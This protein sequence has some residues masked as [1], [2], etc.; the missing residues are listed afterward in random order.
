[1]HYFFAV[2]SDCGEDQNNIHVGELDPE[3]GEIRFLAN[4]SGIGSPTW[5]EYDPERKLLY[6]GG[7]FSDDG[8]VAV[9]DIRDRSRLVLKKI[10]PVS[11]GASCHQALD[12]RREFLAVSFYGSGSLSLVRLDPEGIPV[13]ETCHIVHNGHSVHEKRQREPHIHYACFI[14]DGL[15]CCDLGEDRIYEYRLDRKTGKLEDTGKKI[16]TVPGDGPRHFVYSPVRDLLYVVT[17][18]GGNVSVFSRKDGKLLQRIDS[19]PEDVDR[20]VLPVI[21]YDAYGAAIH[22]LDENHILVS[23]RGHDSISIFSV[24]E[25]GLLERCFTGRIN[26]RIPRDFGILGKYIISANQTSNDLTVMEIGENGNSF[27]DT[28]IRMP[29]AA[30]T[31]VVPLQ[32]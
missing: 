18:M 12:G 22:W 15:Y 19:I 6:T 26:G 14:G 11:G 28:G 21:D 24:L 5:L 31:R 23:N 2:G 10:L 29:V 9:Y 17:E 7:T 8:C 4:A 30:P 25:D 3:K 32:Y 16:L 27:R 13:E 1:M 20:A